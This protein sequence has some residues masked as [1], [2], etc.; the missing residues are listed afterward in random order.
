[1]ALLEIL[2]NCT[3]NTHG[4]SGYADKGFVCAFNLQ[5]RSSLCA[6]YLVSCFSIYRRKKQNN[7]MLE[8]LRTMSSL[9]EVSIHA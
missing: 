7:E 1:M 9:Q 8:S 3:R 4:T 5:H 2:A 6:V